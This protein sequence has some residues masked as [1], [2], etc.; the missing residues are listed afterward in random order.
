VF[1]P[2]AKETGIPATVWRYYLLST[3]PETAD[4]TFSW[5]DCVAANNSVLLN[6]FGNFVNRALKFISVQ[7]GGVIPEGDTPGPLSPND[8]TDAEFVT[9]VNGLLKD[10]TDAMDAV[11][12]RLGLQTVMLLSQRGNLYLQSSGLNKAL[13]AENPT[14]CAQVVSRAANLIYLLS[15]LVYPF[16]PATS[17][18]ILSQLNAPARTVPDMFSIDLLPGHHIGTPAHLFTKIEE[19]KADVWRAE[20]AG[21]DP[22]AAAAPIADMAAAAPATTKR[23][24]AATKKGTQNV[25]EAGQLNGPKSVEALALDAKIAGQGNI[26]RE[27]KARAPRTKEL[28]EETAIAIAELKKLKAERAAMSK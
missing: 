14:R 22:A 28:A 25:A 4:A 10:Y 27:L 7:Y 3:R 17:A 6:N 9:H 15:A 11:K 12:L 2:A 20:F 24:A 18:S 19:K 21:K 23:K 8:E 13:M 26:V 16:M 5:D 1:G